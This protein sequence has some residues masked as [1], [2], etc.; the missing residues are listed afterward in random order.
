M[1]AI[2]DL[3]LLYSSLGTDLKSKIFFSDI[4]SVLP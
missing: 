1:L 2:L 3:R 4:S